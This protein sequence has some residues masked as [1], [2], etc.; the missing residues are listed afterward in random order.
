MWADFC[1]SLHKA[2]DRPYSKEEGA[3]VRTPS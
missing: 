3:R 2:A 1:P